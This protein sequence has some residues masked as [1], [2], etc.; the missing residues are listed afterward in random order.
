[1]AAGILLGAL[2]SSLGGL[3]IWGYVKSWW[4]EN[5]A[6][7]IGEELLEAVKKL[8]LG[9]EDKEVLLK[10]I[11]DKSLR[12]KLDKLVEEDLGHGIDP[13]D[14]AQGEKEHLMKKMI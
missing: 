14:S 1:M 10:M 6:K 12:D 11:S 3:A 7:N 2:D 9:Q 4:K 13:K 8:D 5:K